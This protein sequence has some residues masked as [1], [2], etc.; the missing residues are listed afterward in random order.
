MG[1]RPI[2]TSPISDA[3][4]PGDRVKWDKVPDIDKLSAEEFIAQYLATC[5]PDFVEWYLLRQEERD[6]RARGGRIHVT[7][8]RRVC[9]DS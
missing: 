6:A 3:S 2:P 1:H 8:N 9:V 4:G 5:K 7:D